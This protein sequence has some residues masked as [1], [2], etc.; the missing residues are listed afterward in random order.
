MSDAFYDLYFKQTGDEFMSYYEEIE[1]KQFE[2]DPE[3]ESF[4][5]PCPCGDI[6]VITVEDLLEGETIARCQSCSLIVNCIY[7]EENIKEYVSK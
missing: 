6:F 3:T 2:Y 4:S 7:T 5:Y 1:L